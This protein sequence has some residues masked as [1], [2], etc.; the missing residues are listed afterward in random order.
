MSTFQTFCRLFAVLT[1]FATALPVFAPSA[2]HAAGP[3]G[4]YVPVYSSV[5]YGNK[6]R[7]INLT[8]MLS[9]RN[10]DPHLPIS[11]SEVRYINEQGQTVR[12][13]LKAPQTIPPLGAAQFV[14]EERDVAGGMGPS[15][16]IKWSAA[17]RVSQPLAQGVMIGT[18][19]SQGISFITEGRPMQ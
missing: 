15:F 3:F 4:I 19:G 14:I 16:I 11:L 18:V 1:I 9:V 7:E 13:F 12:S 8:T 10:T 2:V 5:I 17:G 6:G